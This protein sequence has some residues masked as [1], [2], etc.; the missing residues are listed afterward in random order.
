M[1]QV[2]SNVNVGE[3]VEIHVRKQYKCNLP[4][5]GRLC[6]KERWSKVDGVVDMHA[7]LKDASK[8]ATWFFWSLIELR[9][10][11]SNVA[12]FIPSNP[13][14]A[15]KVTKAYK[16][17][18]EAQILKRIRRGEYMINPKAFITDGNDNFDIM[19]ATWDAL[20]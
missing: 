7:Y 2:L 19:V 20:P 11:T 18:K 17:L 8:T 1:T 5:Y 14:E 16:E 10:H 4:S 3:S 12:K 15:R 6:N 9:V 13:V